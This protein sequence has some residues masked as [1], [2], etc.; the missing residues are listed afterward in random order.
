[1]TFAK[2]TVQASALLVPTL[3]IEIERENPGLLSRG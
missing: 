3:P 1:M 2:V